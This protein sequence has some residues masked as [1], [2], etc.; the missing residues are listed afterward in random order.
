[1]ATEF[2]EL[3]I[4]HLQDVKK[5]MK[6]ADYLFYVLLLIMAVILT[7]HRKNKELIF[8]LLNY[9]GKFTVITTIFLGIVSLLFFDLIFS[10][11]HLLFFP[12][13][14]WLFAADSLLIQTFPLDFFVTVSRNI[15]VL[16]ISLGILF[17]LSEYSKDYVF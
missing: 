15:F 4:S 3:E 13:G 17:I 5:V 8:Q 14:N 12:H 10:L 9:G 1:M 11:F 6:Y 7:C 2:T 16:T